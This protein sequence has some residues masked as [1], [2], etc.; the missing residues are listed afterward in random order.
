MQE[1]IRQLKG[2]INKMQNQINISGQEL[3]M[4][5]KTNIE[6]IVKVVVSILDNSKSPVKSGPA[7][8]ENNIIDCDHCSFK[9]E[10][11]EVMVTHV[12]ED[13]EEFPYCYFCGEYF[14]TEKSLKNLEK[15][16]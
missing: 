14:G 8:K 6:E 11:D 10:K 5:Q 9:C 16:E 3:E 15:E 4:S 7:Q 2:I 1:E 13:H 12:R